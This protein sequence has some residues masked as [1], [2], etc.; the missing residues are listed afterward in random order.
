VNPTSKSLL[1][2]ALLSGQAAVNAALTDVGNGL[3]N[4]PDAQMTWVADAN[5]FKTQAA[6]SGNAAAFVNTIISD[7]GRP[8][9]SSTF[10]NGVTYGLTSADFDT[11][12]GAMTWFGA[13]AWVNYLNVANY[14]GYSDWR[15]PNIGGAGSHP[16]V[17]GG[18]CY[19]T[20]SG[21]PISSSEWW[22]LF[23][24]EL[25][26]VQGSP[27]T[28]THNSSYALFTNVLGGYWSNGLGNDSVNTFTDLANGFGTD[29][30]QGRNNTNAMQ[31]VWIVRSGL[32]VV[33]PPPMAHLVLVPSA[34]L[35]FGNQV[36]GTVSPSQTVTITS[37]GTGAAS[38]SVVA[39][40]DFVATNN[41]PASLSP[42]SNCTIGIT[43]N[44]TAVDARTGSLTV[45]AGAVYAIALSGTGTIGVSVTPSALTVTA[46][47]PVTLTW[48]STAG[49]VC[50]ASSTGTADGW[51]GKLAANGTMAVTETAAATYTYDLHCTQ[52]SQGAIGDAVVTDTIPSVSLSANPTNLTVG[53]PTTLTWSSSNAM[54]CSASSNGT[55]WTGTKPTS[56][57][58]VVTDSTVGLITYTLA[59]ASG[60]QSVQATTQVFD[61]AQ[62][63]QKG[64]GGALDLLS[65]F[66][67]LG[68]L[69]VRSR[70]GRSG[71]EPRDT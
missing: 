17:C 62:P 29:G 37:T 71:F 7:W 59:C 35:S 40:G 12:G 21:Y 18:A 25:G 70:Y 19:P 14:K 66:S 48:S 64:G 2:L 39:S 23:F 45:T 50:T 36:V 56:G 13:T 33:S 47:V 46:G 38:I 11:S 30:S 5:L 43:F 3:I 55:G 1:A 31:S 32:S 34:I 42:G 41:C 28:T 44:P 52:G 6:Q 9:T 60:P 27:I 51:N 68:I 61:N 15:L 4:D 65:L 49:S 16:G 53:Q 20:N 8:F 22:E 10:N 63:Q 24:L 67:L 26:G 69:G 57:S 58:T 54:S